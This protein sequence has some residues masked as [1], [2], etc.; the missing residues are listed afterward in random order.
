MNAVSTQRLIEKAMRLGK[1]RPE[2]KEKKGGEEGST[3]HSESWGGQ[4]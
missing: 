1:K 3:G 2:E 4:K